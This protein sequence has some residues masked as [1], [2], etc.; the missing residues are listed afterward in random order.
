[1]HTVC[2]TG[3]PVNL[4]GYFLSFF[5]IILFYFF[6]LHKLKKTFSRKKLLFPTP[7]PCFI[8]EINYFA[9]IL[10]GQTLAQRLYVKRLAYEYVYL[11]WTQMKTGSQVSSALNYREN[12]FIFHLVNFVYFLSL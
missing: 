12:V 8:V 2:E 9:I 10:S 5:K 6:V 1:M 3:I 4:K 7:N 11:W